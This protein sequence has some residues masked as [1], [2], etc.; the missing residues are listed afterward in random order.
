MQQ[1]KITSIED[2]FET[3]RRELFARL[4]EMDKV[5]T[6]KSLQLQRGLQKVA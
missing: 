2:L 3:Q 5:Q 6:T 4:G 1:R